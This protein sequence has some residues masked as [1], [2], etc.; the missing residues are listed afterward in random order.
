MRRTDSKPCTMISLFS[1]LTQVVNP[2]RDGVVVRAS[3]SQSVDLRSI[4]LVE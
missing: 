3:N 4:S 2:R 1:L